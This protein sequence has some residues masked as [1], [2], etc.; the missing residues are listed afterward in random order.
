MLYGVFEFNN[1]SI[2]EIMTPRNNMFTIDIDDNIE[3]IIDEI[4][5]SHFS[6]IPVYKDN[7]DNIVGV[8][9]V[10]DLL[11]EARKVGFNNINIKSILQEPNF[12]LETI[13]TNE[14]FNRLKTS[15]VHLAILF[16]EYGGISGLVS[17]EDL[18]EEIVGDIEDEYDSEEL[19]IKKLDNN[20]FIVKGYLNVSEFN[21]KFNTNIEEGEYDTLNGYIL[22]KLGMLPKVGTEI[23]LENF[24]FVVSNVDNRRIEDIQVKIINKSAE[25]LI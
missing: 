4:L 12:V 22:D 2:K 24:H 14:L 21:N 25:G 8:L 1:K 5:E 17:M 20:N 10:K 3:D 15:K 19:T 23:E 6:R 18:I 7:I 13:K 16:D 11:I 9:Y